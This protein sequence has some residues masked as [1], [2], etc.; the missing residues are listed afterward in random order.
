MV[1]SVQGLEQLA[2]PRLGLCGGPHL[3]HFSG[4]CPMSEEIEIVAVLRAKQG[5]GDELAAIV[6]DGLPDARAETGCLR[7]DLFR[8]RR[9]D[10]SVVMLER[11]ASRDAL[12]EHSTSRHFQE[13][14]A[15]FAALLEAP[16]AVHVLVPDDVA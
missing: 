2:V 8:V 16:P 3:H 6:K 13:L 4:G 7:Y 11:W 14:T 5:R 10:D 12:R 9:D 15:R 1:Y